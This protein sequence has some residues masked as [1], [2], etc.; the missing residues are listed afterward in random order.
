MLQPQSGQNNPHRSCSLRICPYSPHP[1]L[2]TPVPRGCR[3]Y[4]T[5][6]VNHINTYHGNSTRAHTQPFSALGSLPFPAL[7][8][9][10]SSSWTEEKR[11]ILAG[12]VSS[13]SSWIQDPH[14][15]SLDL[16]GLTREGL[17]RTSPTSQETL[18]SP[19]LPPYLGGAG[20]V[21]S[22]FEEGARIP[23]Y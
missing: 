2:P 6:S 17:Q 23:L 18:A 22:T 4:W 8:P 14:H 10:L 5:H 21:G 19:R 1:Q 13:S 20:T 9:L 7:L 16:Q 3:S 11:L 15:S 12:L